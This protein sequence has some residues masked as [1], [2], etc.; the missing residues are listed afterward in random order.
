LESTETR[1]RVLVIDDMKPLVMILQNGLTR[2]GYTVSVALSGKE[3]LTIFH[4]EP[5][6]AVICDL[7]MEGLTGLEVAQAIRSICEAQ[8]LPRPAFVLLTGWGLEV[9]NTI[10]HRDYG[11]DA[12]LTKP[13]EIPELLETLQRLSNER[14]QG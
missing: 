9:E 3:G 7:A 8:S 11:V 10:H 4:T 14:R 1:T 6:D 12:V 5:F 13:V 2:M